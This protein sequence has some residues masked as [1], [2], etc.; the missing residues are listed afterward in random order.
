MAKRPSKENQALLDRLKKQGVR[1]LIPSYVDMHGISKGKTVPIEHF[2]RM[3]SGSELCTGAALDGVPQVVQDEEI[4]AHPDPKSATILPWNPEMCWF[5]SDLWAYGKP[6]EANG[7]LILKR[8]LEAAAKMGFTFNVGI[9]CEFFVLREDENGEHVPVSELDDIDKAAYDTRLT[10]HNYAWLDEIVSS[11][12]G[13]GWDVYS[14]DHEDTNGQW[15]IDFAYADALTMSDRFTFFRLMLKEICREHGL[16][17]TFMPKPWSNRTGSGAHLNMSLADK[18]TGKNLFEDAKDRRECDTSKLGYKFIAGV[19]KHAQAIV[20]VT[21][22]TV[23]SYKRLTVSGSMTGYTWAPAFACYGG[24]NRTNLLRVPLGGG[25]VECRGADI[26]MNPYLGMALALAAGLEGIRE[27]ADPGEPH[28]ENVYE[29]SP[30]QRR[31]EKIKPLP[32]TLVEG[33]DAV[34]RD[35][36]VEKVFGKEMFDSWVQFREEEWASYHNHVSDWE[37]KRYLKFW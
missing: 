12:N 35:P 4:A 18:K 13:L 3:M 34:K 36:L 8:Q 19:L 29:K 31:R 37:R 5:A 17:A 7:R 25:R 22:P 27:N 28:M 16:L 24:N 23:N 14:F 10:L 15:E 32:R 1:Y 20:A 33:I 21:C 6:F 26:G 9:E 2:N 11:M 30:A